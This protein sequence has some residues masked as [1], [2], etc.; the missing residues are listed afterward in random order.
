[1]DYENY[2]QDKEISR[3]ELIVD[4]LDQLRDELLIHVQKGDFKSAER[5]SKE[6][7]SLIAK[8]NS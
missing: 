2:E 5:V 7:E 3:R 4:E 8:I 6:I 1:M